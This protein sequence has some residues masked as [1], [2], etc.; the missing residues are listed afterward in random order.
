MKRVLICIIHAGCAVLPPE[1]FQRRHNIIKVPIDLM[2]PLL[3]HLDREGNP[4]QKTYGLFIFATFIIRIP[5]AA[6]RN[7][8]HLRNIDN[9]GRTLRHIEFFVFL[10]IIKRHTLFSTSFRSVLLSISRIVQRTIS[11]P[12]SDPSLHKV[13]SKNRSQSYFLPKPSDLIMLILHRFLVFL[14]HSCG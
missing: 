10:L 7:I 11:T 14:R 4:I 2:I 3:A 8:I 5:A 9:R 12:P 1:P 13:Y 6:Y